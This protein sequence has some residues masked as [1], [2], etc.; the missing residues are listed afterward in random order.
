MQFSLAL[1][2]AVPKHH[3][4]AL[5]NASKGVVFL[6]IHLATSYA[7]KR[8]TA[9]FHAR[10]SGIGSLMSSWPGFASSSLIGRTRF[11]VRALHREHQNLSRALQRSA[12]HPLHSK[13]HHRP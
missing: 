2:L 13:R 3:A 9:R 1:L 7:R 11:P 5:A 12:L 4:V 6:H 8:L 10:S